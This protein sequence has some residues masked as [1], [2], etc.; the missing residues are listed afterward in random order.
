MSQK[1]TWWKRGAIKETLNANDTLTFYVRYGDYIGRT[2]RF[3]A[4]M[5]VL[6][7]VVN[8]LMN[9]GKKKG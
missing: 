3:F 4:M 2:A 8:L 9:L 7:T 1:I 6:L 5:V